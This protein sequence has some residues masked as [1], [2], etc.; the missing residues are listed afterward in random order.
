[1]TA[2]TVSKG[3]PPKAS[4]LPDLLGPAYPLWTELHETILA[5]FA[6]ATERWVYAGR[7]YGWSCRLERGKKGILYM[8]LDAGYLRV[9]MALSDAA[10]EAV[11]ASDLPATLRDELAAATRAM[12]GW[13]LRMAVRSADDVAIVLKLAGLKKAASKRT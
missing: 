12:E 3:E 11:L 1:M 4:E 9:G 5:T 6:P 2:T 8:W 10:R 13:P 7:K